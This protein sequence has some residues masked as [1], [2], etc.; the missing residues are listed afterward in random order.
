MVVMGIC[1]ILV[2]LGVA[3]QVYE[4]SFLMLVYIAAQFVGKAIAEKFFK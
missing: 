1:I 4:L 2:A 3:F